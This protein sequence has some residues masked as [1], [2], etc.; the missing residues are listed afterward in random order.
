MSKERPSKELVFGIETFPPYGM[1]RPTGQLPSEETA[2]ST[3]RAQGIFV[4]MDDHD[5]F[6]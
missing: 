5:A 1:L 6:F 2:G 3:I 4:T